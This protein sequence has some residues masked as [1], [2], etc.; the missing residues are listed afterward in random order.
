MAQKAADTD[1]PVIA[2]LYDVGTLA[3]ILQMLRL[4]DGTVKVL[5]E[6]TQRARVSR[7][8]DNGDYLSASFAPVAE[9]EAETEQELDAL[10]RSAVA[11]FE[12]YAKLNKKVPAEL[13]PS[14]SSMDSAGRLAD[15][16]AAHLALKL[17]DKQRVLESLEAKARLE[18]TLVLMEGEMDTLQ[19][20][21]KI[22]DLDEMRATLAD[23][24]AACAGDSRPDCP[25][26]A[27][28]ATPDDAPEDGP[29]GP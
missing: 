12:Q 25:I 5:V 2:D 11:N 8:V 23:L 29:D 28:L 27:S 21:R 26:L 20:E 7:I 19:I 18:L 15:T 16:I 22:R 10:M 6:G 3:S 24:V 17:E 13:L 14:L 1:E 4:P 9:E